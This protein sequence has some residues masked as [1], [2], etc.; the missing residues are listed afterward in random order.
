MEPR[1]ALLSAVVLRAKAQIIND[2]L[3]NVFAARPAEG[4][5][6]EITC[7]A[8][9]HDYVDANYYGGAFEDQVS[10]T[11]A[12]AL[13]MQPPPPDSDEDDDTF[14]EVIQQ[15]FNPMQDIVSDWIAGGGI[16]RVADAVA[17]GDISVHCV[18]ALAAGL[19]LA[20]DELTREVF[21]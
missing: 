8:D 19:P 7:Y 20:C 18:R 5:S 3:T 6:G 16:R 13:G 2:H 14:G 9:L 15:F 11:L 21:L 12:L 17:G 10:R 1:E 4:K